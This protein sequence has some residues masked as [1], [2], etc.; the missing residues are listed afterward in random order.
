LAAQVWVPCEPQVCFASGL[1]AP[2]FMHADQAD[3]RPLAGSQVRVC[4]PQL[5]HA[6]VVAPWHSWSVHALAHW[7]LAPHTCVPFEPQLR[8][9]FG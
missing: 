3:K 1:H 4:R 6:W 2:W 8:T 5:P 7:Q 9:S